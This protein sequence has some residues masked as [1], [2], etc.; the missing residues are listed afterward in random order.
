MIG[1]HTRGGRNLFILGIGAIAIALTSTS[2][3]LLIYH[4]SGDIYLDRSRPGFLP[5]EPEEVIDEGSYR[6]PENG[7]IDP[8]GLEEYLREL[9]KTRQTSEKLD[10]PFGPTPLS[11]EALGITPYACQDDDCALD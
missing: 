2:L 6:F 8:A 9:K 7:T 4:N 5:E 11:D 10:D 1:L 3:G